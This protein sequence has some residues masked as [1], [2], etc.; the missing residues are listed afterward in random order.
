[1]LLSALGIL[2]VLDSHVGPNFSNH[3][4]V[5]PYGSFF[6]PMFAFI[7]G[8]FFSEKH[9][10]SWKH[11]V[12][13]IIRKIKALLVPYFLWIVFYGVVTAIFRYFGILKI[14]KISWIDLIHNI[15][16]GGTSFFFNDPAWFVPLL[17][18][19]ITAYTILR[20]IANTHWNHYIA[21]VVFALLGAGA[22]AL[23]QTDFR[24]HNTYMLMKVPVFLQH[25][26]MGVL[27]KEK[28]E[29]Y[30][31]RFHPI[32]VCGAAAIVNL[33]LISIYGRNISF[34]MYATMDGYT[35]NAPFLPLIT[36]IT[37]I[38]FWLKICKVSAPVLGENKVLNFISD[39]TF[40]FM[41][42]HLAI[43]HIWLGA[44]IAFHNAGIITL[45]GIDFDQYQK[46][47]WY[48]YNGSF[49]Q[50]VLC[51]LFTTGSLVVICWLYLKFQQKLLS[52]KKT[53][54]PN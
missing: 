15:I 19:V 11:V 29:K 7:S 52:Y 24:T 47:A 54:Q 27:F 46:Y 39:N 35:L 31:D 34:P 18:C 21:M 37:G 4:V 16:T 2:F 3:F 8:Y 49:L 48:V 36:S 10:Q 5:F 12:Q 25:Y 51:L 33:I 13:F 14:G 43:K 23:S 30:F 44:L 42:H 50:S 38:A 6:M 22:V 9:I 32:L 17:F 26:H 40:F 1:M 28:L 20:K 45:P 41:T 53:T